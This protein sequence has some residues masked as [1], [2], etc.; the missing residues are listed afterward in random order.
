MIA[1]LLLVSLV[2]DGDVADERA[3]RRAALADRVS[4]PRLVPFVYPGHRLVRTK[5]R[6]EKA[7]GPGGE[8]PDDQVTNQIV[9]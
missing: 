1:R 6:V 7:R 3:A 2:R 9:H 8:A 4:D 5:M